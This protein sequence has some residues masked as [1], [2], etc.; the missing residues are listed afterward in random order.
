MLQLIKLFDTYCQSALSY[1][2]FQAICF[3]SISSSRWKNNLSFSSF[4]SKIFLVKQSWII[5]FRETGSGGDKRNMSPSQEEITAY[6]PLILREG[7]QKHQ[8]LFQLPLVCET[9]RPFLLSSATCVSHGGCIFGY[10]F[11]TGVCFLKTRGLILSSPSLSTFYMQ[12]HKELSPASGEAIPHTHV[13]INFQE[14]VVMN[15]LQ[16]AWFWH[17]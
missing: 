14:A 16:A 1:D 13:E 8:V 6:S 5:T 4:F 3:I 15:M 17:L 10:Q 2:F 7:I 9:K 11:W 12:S